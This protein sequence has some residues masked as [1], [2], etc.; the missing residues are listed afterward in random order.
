[1]MPS[2]RKYGNTS[3]VIVVSRTLKQTVS[4]SL[5]TGIPWYHSNAGWR[6]VPLRQA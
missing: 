1:M 6:L 2:A 3:S 4:T 5:S